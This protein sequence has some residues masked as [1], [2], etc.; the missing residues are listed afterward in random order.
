MKEEGKNLEG[1]RCLS[2]RDGLLDFSEED[3]VKILKEHV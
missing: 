3:R 1:E 2:G